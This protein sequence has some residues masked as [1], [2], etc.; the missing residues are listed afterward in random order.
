MSAA[1]FVFDGVLAEIGG[2][3]WS[4]DSRGVAA[5][6]LIPGVMSGPNQLAVSDVAAVAAFLEQVFAAE[7]LERV[8]DGTGR[9][10]R[11]TVRVDGVAWRIV[12]APKT[13]PL[14]LFMSVTDVDV[15]FA[16]AVA[17]G[18]RVLEAPNTRHNGERIAGVRDGSDISWWLSA[19]V[20]DLS[21]DEV[22]R[23]AK[24]THS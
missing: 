1:D 15:T 18:A 13:P 8:P 20:E 21:P 16:R 17:S 7:I 2:G 10:R 6:S 22:A 12:Y 4:T 11:A 9:V 14:G 24:Q 5:S 3:A 19:I 23:R